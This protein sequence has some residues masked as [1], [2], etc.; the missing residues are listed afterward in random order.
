MCVDEGS[1]HNFSL[2]GQAV[3]WESGLCEAENSAGKT[4]LLW[5]WGCEANLGYS[6]FWLHYSS[7]LQGRSS[8]PT[9]FLPLMSKD[10]TINRLTIKR[11]Q[12]D[13]TADVADTTA[14][15]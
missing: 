10:T 13:T 5:G 4:E 15:D 8:Q 6:I 12:A 3:T 11:P 1:V 14:Y 9:G 2:I 7:G